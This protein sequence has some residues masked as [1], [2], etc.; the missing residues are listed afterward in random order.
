M[1]SLSANK[2]ARPFSPKN[3]PRQV[4]LDIISIL[5]AEYYLDYPLLD[6]I[7]TPEREENPFSPHENDSQ[8]VSCLHFALL[9]VR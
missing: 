1:P 2:G 6:T 4:T 7:E 3:P 9:V 5:V 8:L